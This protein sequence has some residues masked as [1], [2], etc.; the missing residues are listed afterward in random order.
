MKIFRFLL[1]TSKLGSCLA[2]LMGLL[3]GVGSIALLAL[4]STVLAQGRSS[5]TLLWSFLGLC[6]LVPA[7]RIASELFLIHVGQMTIFRL[8]MDLSRRVL[9]VP[10]R[11]LEELGS[12]RL[13]STLTEDIAAIG[14]AVSMLPIICINVAIFLGGLVYLCWLSWQIFMVVVVLVAVGILGYQL[15]LVQA[16]ELFRRARNRHDDLYDHLRSL[17]GGLKELKLHSQRREAFLSSELE[18][19]AAEFRRDNTAGMRI[20]TLASSWGQ[21]LVFA[22]IG[23]LMFLL[24]QFLDFESRILTGYILTLLYLMTPLQVALNSSATL[25]RANVALSKVES[26]GIDISSGARDG[27]VPAE[28]VREPSWNRIDLAQA[29]HAYRREQEEGEFVLGPIDLT[30]RPGELLF[31]AGGNG[32]GKTTLAKLITGLYTP[33]QGEI[34][35]DGQLVTNKNRDTYRQRFSVVFSDFHLFR[36]LLGLEAD[37]L[38]AQARSFLAQLRL[39]AKVQIEKGRLSTTELSQGQRKRLAL[40]T[41]YLEDRP[42]YLFD[43]WAADQDPVFK[44]VFYRHILPILK[45]RGKTAVVITH[46]DRYYDTADRLIKLENGKIVEET[47][48]T[49]ANLL[50]MQA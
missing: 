3:S 19:T 40:L 28:A 43:E 15:P 23:G 20:Y 1:H 17:T 45:T 27:E 32:S 49:S 16:H 42:I 11:R 12:H 46:D 48:Q 25:T 2:I 37:N 7:S 30:L 21:L 14:N 35:M 10:L 41:A 8:R 18:T 39:D 38:D 50:A 47:P 31:I 36:S 24:P 9:A 13:L 22:L 5:Q 44:E 29:T 26:L 33:D 34:L 4:I 6:L